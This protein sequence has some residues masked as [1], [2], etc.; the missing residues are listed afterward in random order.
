MRLG[1]PPDELMESVCVLGSGLMLEALE[2]IKNG[3]ANP[4]ERHLECPIRAA[5]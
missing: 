2:E 4:V 3:N 5:M 1:M